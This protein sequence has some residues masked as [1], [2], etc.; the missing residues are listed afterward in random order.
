M[1]LVLA[2]A[3]LSPTLPQTAVSD[4]FPVK[5][6][7]KWVYEET[8][9]QAKRPTSTRTYTDSVGEIEEVAGLKAVPLTT[10]DSQG[11]S[12]KVH[13][14]MRDDSVD[15]LMTFE[16]DGE[17]VPLMYPVLK[18][19]SERETSW[20]YAGKTD[21]AGD[22]VD[23]ILNATSRPSGTKEVLG[24]KVE[25]LEVKM[26]VVINI[27]PEDAFSSLQGSTV[28]TEQVATYAKGIG[29]VEVKEKIKIGKN[30]MERTRK[31]VSYSIPSQ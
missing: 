12:D 8:M 19:S 23:M 10:R 15:I 22:P 31:L 6:G 20:N 25:T 24:Q 21:F 27:I 2:L 4:F 17:T 7:S 29:L 16:V 30:T 9:K 13:Y 3:I 1:T 5:P 28:Q 26:D 11:S 14:V 18:T